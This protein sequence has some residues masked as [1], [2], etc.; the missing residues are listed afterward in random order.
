[1]SDKKT[2]DKSQAPPPTPE[3]PKP[4]QQQVREKLREMYGDDTAATVRRFLSDLIR[5]NESD[6]PN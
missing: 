2:S 5:D 3:A 1:M 6:L 4:G